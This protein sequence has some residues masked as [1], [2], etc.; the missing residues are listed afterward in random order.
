MPASSRQRSRSTRPAARPWPGGPRA[1][2]GR[3]GSAAAP[4]GR[5]LVV[6]QFE[7]TLSVPWAGRA[8]ARP[9]CCAAPGRCRRRSTATARTAAGARGR[10]GGTTGRSGRR[11]PAGPAQHPQRDLTQPLPGLV[12][13]QLEDRR[14]PAFTSRAARHAPGE[15]LRVELIG[16]H[17]HSSRRMPASSTPVPRRPAGLAGDLDRSVS[18]RIDPRSSP[19]SAVPRSK[20]KVTGAQ[21]SFSAPT[22]LPT[23]M[24]TSSRNISLNSLSP[25]SVRMKRTSMPG[26]SMGMIAR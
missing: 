24:R 9:R 8:G 4:T 10:G 19:T 25:V 12:V 14:H 3:R 7:S 13:G 5:D 23:R 2:P 17:H 18:R 26:E 1:S 15:A 22:T 20:P 6:G 11:A 21:P 16:A